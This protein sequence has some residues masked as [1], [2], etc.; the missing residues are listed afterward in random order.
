MAEKVLFHFDPRCPW[1]WQTSRWADQLE[2]LGEI[3]IDWGVFSLE[4]VNQ[5]EGEELTNPVSGPALRTAIAIRD[6]H[7]R[8]AI[9]PFYTALGRR[10]WDQV[11]PP[12]PEGMVEAVRE[13]LVEAGLEPE[14]VDKAMADTSTWQ[15][16]VDEHRD[17]VDRVGGFGVPT[18]VLDGGKGPAIFGPV[19]ADLPTDSDAVE[20]W[21]HTSWL[22]RYD[23]F[24]ELKRN[25]DRQPDLPAL[26]WMMEQRR[27]RAE[28]AAKS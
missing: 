23:N 20:L 7:G 12:R 1:C 13:S 3:E 5:K 2:R 28:E 9:G 19:V 27:K 25:R 4:I 26:H 24:Y 10:L 14:L 18:I 16:V 6:A 21:K 15:A 17:L 11:P 8:A 22:V